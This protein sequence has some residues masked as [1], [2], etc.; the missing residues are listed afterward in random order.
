[1]T[2]GQ[3][4]LKDGAPVIVLPAQP[5]PPSKAAFNES[6]TTLRG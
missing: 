6:A 5:A 1:V 3:M 4:K 2:D